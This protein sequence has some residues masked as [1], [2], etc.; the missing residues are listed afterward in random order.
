MPRLFGIIPAMVTPLDK[1]QAL[2][3]PALRLSWPNILI[4]SRTRRSRSITLLGYS[5]QLAAP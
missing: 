2:S 4:R 5:G 1:N 3:E